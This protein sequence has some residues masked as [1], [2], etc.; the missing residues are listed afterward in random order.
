MGDRLR[1]VC[2]EALAVRQK[3]LANLSANC[4]LLLPP[5]PPLGQAEH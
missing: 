1:L 4:G 3:V 5:V 2:C